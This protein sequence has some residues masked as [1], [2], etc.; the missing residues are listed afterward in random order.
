MSQWT[1]LRGAIAAT[2]GGR[3]SGPA[4]PTT[5]TAQ[6]VSTP[7]LSPPPPTPSAPR[8]L[9][10]AGALWKA[11]TYSWAPHNFTP[12]NR[13]PHVRPLAQ[14]NLWCTSSPPFCCLLDN[15]DLQLPLVTLEPPS[16]TLQLPSVTLQPPSVTLQPPSA[17]LQP[18]SVTLQPPSVSL[19]PPSVTLQPPSVTTATVVS[20]RRQVFTLCSSTPGGVCAESQNVCLHI[21]NYSYIEMATAC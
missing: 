7:A 16:V 1:A 15:V 17:T 9:G 12:E 8:L 19:Q 13:P 18:P 20:F 21:H 11:P 4:H 10:P 6:W 5:G 14:D 3:C 2:G